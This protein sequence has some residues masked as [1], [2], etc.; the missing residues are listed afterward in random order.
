MLGCHP[1]ERG[2]ESRPGRQYLKKNPTSSFLYNPNLLRNL[3]SS[4][5]I[6]KAMPPVPLPPEII[7]FNLVDV[8]VIVSDLENALKIA[9]MQGSEELRK[10]VKNISDRR[11]GDP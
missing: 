6:A 1:S 5:I 2:F 10:K 11:S 7:T 9:K 4:R 3:P 8:E